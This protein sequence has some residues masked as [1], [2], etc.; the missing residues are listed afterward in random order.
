MVKTPG[1]LSS[2]D[3]LD[4]DMPSGP[5]VN[6]SLL[7][8]LVAKSLLKHIVFANLR[9]LGFKVKTCHLLKWLQTTESKLDFK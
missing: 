3:D 6:N 8:K 5:P 1:S 4:P 2:M 9:I 7:N